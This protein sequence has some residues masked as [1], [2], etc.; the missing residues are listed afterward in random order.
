M[1]ESALVVVVRRARE[2]VDVPPDAVRRRER[3]Q[4]DARRVHVH[5]EVGEQ[6]LDEL[7][8]VVEVGGA[9]A[10]AL[11]DEKDQLDLAVDRAT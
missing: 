11:V 1:L 4:G 10:R 6:L 7:E 5:G 9:D 3:D 8:L 2:V